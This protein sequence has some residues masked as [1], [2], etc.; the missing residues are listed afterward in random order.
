MKMIRPFSW[1]LR[2]TVLLV[3][4]GFILVGLFFRQAIFGTAVEDTTAESVEPAAIEKG[5]EK[6]QT[7]VGAA[8]P[9]QSEIESSADMSLPLK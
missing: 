8:V 1:F 7:P 2:H 3:F 9:G 4:L 5:L 6:E